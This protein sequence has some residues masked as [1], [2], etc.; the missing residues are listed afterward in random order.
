MLKRMV[1][2]KLII[3]AASLFALF[4][5][6]L[7]PNDISYTLKDV[8][9][10]TSYVS[11]EMNAQN[12]YLLDQHGLLART[13]I[14]NNKKSTAVTTKAKFIVESLIQDGPNSS[15]IPN[16]FKAILPSDTKLLTVGFEDNI[17]KLNFNKEILE[18]KEELEEKMI[19]AIVYSVTEIEEVTQVI[20]YVENNI[21]TFL[22]KTKTTLPSTLSRS[23]GINKK[24]DFTKPDQV[25]QVT[26]YYVNH[27][28]NEN[29]YVPVTKYVNDEREKVR[30]IV[31]E[32]TSTNSYTGNLMSYLNSNADLLDVKSENDVMELIFNS[33]V[34][35]DMEEKNI[36][37]EVIYTISL[38]IKDN[39]DVNEVVFKVENEAIYKS[40][41]KTIE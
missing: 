16:G 5:I 20:I 7:V 41:L 12:I 15:S 40:V 3:T 34:F 14:V 29:Y 2:K 36:L 26:I 23:F 33:Y 31:D 25:S 24:Y 30:I 22:P 9:S 1:G 21:L 11:K 13:K 19:E 38:S 37:E 6:Y 28:N 10:E 35:S 4:L 39:Y 17:L 27:W 32:L 8:P 18:V